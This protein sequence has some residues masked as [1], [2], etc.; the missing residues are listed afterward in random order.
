MQIPAEL[1]PSSNVGP[2]SLDVSEWDVD[3]DCTECSDKKRIHQPM[4]SHA[5]D[6]VQD[7]VNTLKL[8]LEH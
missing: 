8:P 2:P 7:L 1:S 3:R 6:V 5:L 4:G